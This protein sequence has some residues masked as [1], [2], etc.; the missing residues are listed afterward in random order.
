M[1]KWPSCGFPDRIVMH[2]VLQILRDGRLHQFL[3]MP[4]AKWRV[5]T[6]EITYDEVRDISLPECASVKLP[7]LLHNLMEALA[8][9]YTILVLAPALILAPAPVRVPALVLVQVLVLVLVLAPALY[10]CQQ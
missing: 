10:E 7:Q 5:V 2:E 4:K 9:R 8:A 3:P 1:D 6:I